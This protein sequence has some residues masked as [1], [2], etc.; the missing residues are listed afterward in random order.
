[1]TRANVVVRKILPGRGNTSVSNTYTGIV[2]E[3]TVDTDLDT[4]RVHDGVTAGGTRLATYQEVQD[5]VTGN[6]DLSGY[7]TTA[8][9]TAANANAAIQAIAINSI[10]A[11]IGA[12]HTYAN[13]TF[14]GGGSGTYSNTNVVA[15]LSHVAG[16]VIPSANGVYSLGDSTHWWKSMYISGQTI[17]IGGVALSMTANGLTSDRGFDL[18]S[19]NA[20]T[21]TSGNIVSDGFFFANGVDIL[22]T[23]TGTGTYSNAN[24]TA[25]LTGSIITGAIDIRNTSGLSISESD[26]TVTDFT[27]DVA[28]NNV[29]LSSLIRGNGLIIRTKPDN[30]GGTSQTVFTVNGT[31]GL[32]TVLNDPTESAGIATKNY[33]DTRDNATRTMLQNNVSAINSNVASNYST[34]LANAAAAHNEIDSL[35][36]NI[37]A[38]NSVMISNAIVQ[39]T[40]IN[41]LR[42]NI[43]AANTVISSLQTQTYSNA[44]VSAYLAGDVT[45]GNLTTGGFLT[46]DLQITDNYI[47]LR[48]GAANDEINIAPS[49]AAGAAYLQLPNDATADQFDTRLHNDVGNVEIGAN[50]HSWTFGHS[51]DLTLPAGGAINY[52]NG[53]S[54]LDGI[55]GTYSN[56]NVAAYL[57]ENPQSGTYSDTNVAA[58]LNGGFMI[59]G[60]INFT[61]SPPAYSSPGIQW[62]NGFQS[63]YFGNTE[64][65]AYLTTYTGNLSAANATIGTFES[66]NFGLHTTGDSLAVGMFNTS[67]L[68]VS[69]NG[70]LLLG[71]TGHVRITG[72]AGS[73]VTI[74]GGSS[75]NVYVPSGIVFNDGTKQ[76]TA[77]TGYGDANVEAYIGGNVGAYQVWANTEIG[78][79]APSASPTFTGNVS[80]QGNVT[81]NNNLAVLGNLTV[82]GTTTTVNA[83]TLTLTDKVITVANGSTTNN[84]ANGAGLY[85][86]GSAANIL[87]TSIDDAWTLNKTISGTGNIKAASYMIG[88][89]FVYANGVNI[90]S[91]LY[92]NAGVQFDAINNLLSIAS[93]QS[94][95]ISALESNAAAQ[96]VSINSLTTNAAT[97][98]TSINTL[99]ANIGAYQTF[100]NANATTQ[101]TSINTISANLG[102]Y[103]TFANANAAAQATSITTLT[104]N[105]AT[106]QTSINSISANLGAYQTYANATFSV[107]SYGNANVAGYLPVYSGNLQAAN[108]TTLGTYGNITGANVISANTFVFGANGVNILSAVTAVTANLINGSNVVALLSNGNLLLP[109]NM[110][111]MSS[112]AVSTTGIVFGDGKFQRTAYTGPDSVLV[113]GGYNATLDTA[114]NLTVPGSILPNTDNVFD[115]GSATM[116]F[117]HLY[118]GPGTVY[119]GNAAIKTTTTGNLILPGITRALASSAFVEQVEDTG[120][121]SYSFATTPTIIDN[122]QFELL[123]G[124]QVSAFTPATYSSSGIDADGYVRNITVDTA[125]SGYANDVANLAEQNMWA[126]EVADP[127][128]NFNISDWIQIPFRAETRAGESE[129]EFGTGGADLGDLNITGSTLESN[130][131]NNFVNM[132]VDGDEWMRLG[133]YYNQ[134]LQLI[135]DW[136]GNRNIW[137]FAANGVLTLP[138]GGDILNSNGASVLGGGSGNVDLGKF[139]IVT[140][141]GY[142]F[143][144]TTDDADGYGGYNIAINPNGEGSAFI[145]IP[146]NANAELG[147]SLMIASFAANSSVRIRT[148][149]ADPWIFGADGTLT[150]PA[151][152]DILDSNGTSVLGSGGLTTITGDQVGYI[153]TLTQNANGA[154]PGIDDSATIDY[155]PTVTL[156][157]NDWIGAGT[158]DPAT[159]ATATFANGETRLIDGW[160][161]DSHGTSGFLALD[162]P[163]TIAGPDAWPIVITSYD[164]SAGNVTPGKAI[165][166]NSNTWKF[167]TAGNLTF[168]DNTVQ[169]TAYVPYVPVAPVAQ[170]NLMLDGGAAATIYE[171]TVNYAEGG[172]SAT[173]YGVNTPSFDGGA[174]ALEEAIY[175]TLDGGGA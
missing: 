168:P 61:A 2:G 100:A 169:T 99:D 106:Q 10:N 111:F 21:L 40:D 54:I 15:Y 28:S 72:A 5:A 136:D 152:G 141:G 123:S 34:F 135:T 150:L 76:I 164:Y 29:R 157:A 88:S 50:T 122:A 53:V 42:A 96:A 49:G 23:V 38:A 44:N 48:S 82:Q 78:N 7:A 104:S 138:V 16:N 66:G 170:D 45:V 93:G 14:T 162:T 132:D 64:V 58:Y 119:V 117:R 18:A 27:M 26:G 171:V 126:T 112:P 114:G 90:L 116:R 43:T 91:D 6:L 22:T 147:E 129:F 140:D 84:E 146:N 9:I 101:A 113:N 12:F 95:S 131:S 51:G 1:M 105:A 80:A 89:E 83:T 57:V 94:S 65:A 33:V 62:P 175:Y 121:Q 144:T 85:V 47:Q 77:Y 37:I 73:T 109:N 153:L 133:T 86:P 172:F 59:D 145:N 173:R 156:D 127:I 3:I 81:V 151:G 39:A 13:A 41:A 139:K 69:S 160:N 142:A 130:G 67:A 75:G 11:N 115:L 174:A 148:D 63:N 25:Y 68:T 155:V 97:Q 118:V 74:G 125:G 4:I 32:I 120:D 128:N 167:D 166:V 107:S 56:T 161:T 79:K 137:E 60:P 46:T 110:N 20:T 87:Y 71:G 163:I 30:A 149:W 24:V 55:G 19:A 92:S 98:A 8:Q 134:K 154:T 165:V 159:F 31:T 124:G 52:A 158:N 102:A 36:A 143:L 70:N 103:Q 35:R 17:Y 108:I